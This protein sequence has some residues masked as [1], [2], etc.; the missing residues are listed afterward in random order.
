MI[1]RILFAL[2][3]VLNC[4]KVNTKEEKIYFEFKTVHGNLVKTSNFDGKVL[5]VD[6]WATW[7]P[8]CLKEIPHFIELQEKYKNEVKF[9]GL[10]VNEEPDKVIE[11]AK[12]MGINYTI[13]YS[14]EKI[15]NLFG[16]ITGLP[17]TFIIGKDR[18]IKSKAVGYRP[19]EWFEQ[20]IINALKENH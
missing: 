7:C 16:G 19:K 15:E 12:S 2:L 20:Q 5:V 17:T 9:I 8:P 4:N 18:R 6:F 14:D 13:G 10:N 3:F 1:N 11:F